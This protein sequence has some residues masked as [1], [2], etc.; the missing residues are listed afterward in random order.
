MLVIKIQGG[1][2]VGFV[3]FALSWVLWIFSDINWQVIVVG[4]IKKKI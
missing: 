2:I 1:C 3:R 4:E